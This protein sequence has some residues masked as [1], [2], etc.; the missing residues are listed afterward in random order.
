MGGKGRKKE[1]ES[2]EREIERKNRKSKIWK[3]H[4]LISNFY[5]QC[6]R[7]Q[8]STVSQENTVSL[9]TVSG[10]SGKLIN[11]ALIP[12]FSTLCLQSG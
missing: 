1:W 9:S 2:E 5:M 8:V 11:F 3:W 4:F 6:T 7:F 12:I 10:L